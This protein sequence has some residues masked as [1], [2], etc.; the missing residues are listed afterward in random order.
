MINTRKK[1]LRTQKNQLDV[2]KMDLSLAEHMGQATDI[3]KTMESVNEK[4]TDIMLDA[5]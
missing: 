3:M 5:K 1:V 4:M 2:A